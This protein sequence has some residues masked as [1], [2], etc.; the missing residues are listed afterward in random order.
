[1]VMANSIK[2]IIKGKAESISKQLVDQR[3]HLHMYPE[4][5][6]QEERTAAYIL[7]QLEGLNIEISTGWAG[8]GIVVDIMGEQEGDKVVLLRADMD[9]LPILEANEVDYASRNEG[10]MHA[11]EHD[12]HTTVLLGAVNILHALKSEFGGRVRCLFQPGEE[13][14]PGGASI[15]IE[16]GVLKDLNASA[17]FGLHVHPPL[18]AGSVGVKGGLYMASA[19]EIYIEVEGKGG[20]AAVPHNTVDP[21][22][23]SSEIV[24]ALQSV[25]S[26]KGDPAIPSVLS[27]GK[28]NSV[29]GA[30]N[31]IPNVVRMEG[32]FRTM[33]EEWRKK[34][35]IE[36][37]R[38]VEQVAAA[39]GGRANVDIKVGYPCLINNEALVERARPWMSEY[40]GEDKV[41]DLPLRLS[42]EDF[43]YYSHYAP[44]CFYRL[45]TGNISK[46]IVH[47]VH[48]DRFDIDE[49]ALTVGAGMMAWLAI[50]ELTH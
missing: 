25:V 4:L 32:T 24:M 22:L 3:R 50:Q 38:I 6:F 20:H 49:S 18:E 26:R 2:D 21:V 34:A 17:I 29:G 8:H 44:A 37:R 7:D 23:I 12:V 30:T 5:S 39:H 15:M 31:I 13:K 28:I 27:I 42:A 11:C 9:A 45:G 10:I 48:T 33:D 1:M 43:A 36:I 35:H 19:D 47:S 14:L 41:V 46:G 40:L 16:E